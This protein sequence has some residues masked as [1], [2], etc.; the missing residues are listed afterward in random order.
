[1]KASSLWIYIEYKVGSEQWLV[2]DVS[3]KVDERQIMEALILL[4]KRYLTL[5][6]YAMGNVKNVKAEECNSLI[7]CYRKRRQSAVGKGMKEKE[8]NYVLSAD[9]VEIHTSILII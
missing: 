6:L 3:G 7:F 5:V 1:M 8:S 2:G 9:W 4:W